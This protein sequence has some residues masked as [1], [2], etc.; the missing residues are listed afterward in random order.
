MLLDRFLPE[1]VLIL[2]ETRFPTQGHASVGMARQSC[3]ALGK[4]ANCQVAVSVP[5]GTDTTCLPLTW[6]LYLPQAW[7]DD[8]VR[9]TAARIPET[10]TS[11]TKAEL[12]LAALDRVRAGGGGLTRRPG[13]CGLWAPV[14]SFGRRSRRV[15]CPP[16]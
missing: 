5:L 16:A 8:P 3:G 13:R 1:A 14:T 10:I 15:A 9:R 6:G 11:Q 2:D 7:I 12:A 4:M